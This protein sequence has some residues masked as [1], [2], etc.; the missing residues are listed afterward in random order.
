MIAKVLHRDG[1]Y[2][3]PVFAVS[4]RNHYYKAV[5]FDSA[6][7][8]LTVVD[9][10]KDMKHTV[11]FMDFD[12]DDF[13]INEEGLKSYWND[14]NIFRKVEQKWYTPQILD[15][16]KNILS[17]MKVKPFVQIQSKSDL[18]A[19][20]IN[21]G[22]FH[23]GYVLGMTEK[24]GVLEI[25]LDTSWGSLVIL[26]CSG[27]LE[28]T[29]QVGAYFWHADMRLGDGY[30]ELAWDVMGNRE[31]W[32]LKAE[33]IA[34][35]TLFEQRIPFSGTDFLVTDG[36]LYLQQ[37]GGAKPVCFDAPNLDLLDFRE[38]NVLGYMEQDDTICRCF[39]F[40]EDI[41][42]SLRQYSN[43]RKAFMN[44]SSCLQRLREDCEAQGIS[45]D[46]HPSCD[47]CWENLEPD[48]GQ[49]LFCQPYGT[50]QELRSLCKPIF[51][52]LAIYNGFWLIV[53]LLHP[54]MKW[55]VYYVMGLGISAVFFF[56]CLAVCI[57]EVIREKRVGKAGEKK[58]EIYEK[59]I[60]YLGYN[61]SAN[62]IYENIYSVAY[63]KRIIMDTAIGKIRFHK[64]NQD[65]AIYA[66]IAQRVQQAKERTM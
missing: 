41:V 19:L 56:T 15:V 45:F 17:Q 24:N 40:T 55:S 38:R 27:V 25:M 5:V 61:H 58:L 49:L 54:E 22:S 62:L 9:I 16:A 37:K 39:M 46:V 7:K 53:Q 32:T 44:A 23:D 1:V 36:H 31:E 3:S 48:Y 51:F 35:R 50:L 65:P 28:N 2:Y 33:H 21:S 14:R 18:E 43:N 63:K 6:L 60:K 13:A 57:A 12:T 59:G 8:E 11:L 26:R 30:V 20:E 34:F 47:E 10:Y 64:T 4:L 29:L 52:G 66:M 42:Y